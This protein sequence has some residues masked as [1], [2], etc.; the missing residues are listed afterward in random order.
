MN[1]FLK[2]IGWK[3]KNDNIDTYEVIV[4]SIVIITIL[5]LS[6]AAVYLLKL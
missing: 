5:S 4:D 1:N 6:I 3:D 2:L